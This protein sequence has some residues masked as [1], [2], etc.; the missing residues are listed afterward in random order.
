MQWLGQVAVV[1]VPAEIDISNADN[2]RDDLLSV[3]KDGPAAL[4]VDM[5]ETTFCDSAGVN[6][7]VRVYQQALAVSAAVRLVVR[8]SAVQRVLAITGVDRLIDTFPTVDA[9]VAASAQAAAAQEA[10]GHQSPGDTSAT[11]SAAGT[12]TPDSTVADSAYGDGADGDSTDGDGADGDGA[13]PQPAPE[14]YAG[15]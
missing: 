9:A 14:G 12:A 8:A 10:A 6:S 13:E 11:D 5:S 7:L 4:V 2:V 15:H 3:V 1:T